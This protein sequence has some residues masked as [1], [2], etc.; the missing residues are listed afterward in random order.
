MIT[1]HKPSFAFTGTYKDEPQEY[2]W[3]LAAESAEEFTASDLQSGVRATQA[4]VRNKLG[5]AYDPQEPNDVKVGFTF[6]IP[7]TNGDTFISNQ[8]ELDAWANTLLS[9]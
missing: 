7:F 4:M 2:W 1:N 6:L 9:K 8:Q 3:S 5:I